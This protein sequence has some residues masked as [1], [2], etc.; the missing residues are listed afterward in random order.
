MK[1]KVILKSR[2]EL[3]EEARRNLWNRKAAQKAPKYC[4]TVLRHSWCNTVGVAEEKE[5][6]SPWLYESERIVT[7][8]VRERIMLATRSLRIN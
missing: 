3:R 1:G 5:C 7:S 6:V 8:R 2:A 4:L